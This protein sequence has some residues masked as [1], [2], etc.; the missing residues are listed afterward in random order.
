MNT[1][2]ISLTQEQAVMVDSFVTNYGFG[3]RSEFFRSL[4][5]LVRRYPYIIEKADELSFVSPLT[6][7]KSKILNAFK[8][9]NKYSKDFLEDLKTGLDE[10][11]Y[12]K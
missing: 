9:T 12:F 7:N 4:L 11:P 1:V 5:R 6:S 10:S 3:N 8:N 2:N